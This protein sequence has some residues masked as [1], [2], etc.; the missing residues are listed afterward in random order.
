MVA[1][2]A[3]STKLARQEEDNLVTK[4]RY[5]DGQIKLN[6]EAIP[7]EVLTGLLTLFSPANPEAAA[8]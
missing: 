3:E 1:T 7:P 2:L 4:L 6:G 8:H 5:S